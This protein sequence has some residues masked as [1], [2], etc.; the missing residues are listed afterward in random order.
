[1][2]TGA[3]VDSTV[4]V[5]VMKAGRGLTATRPSALRA[6]PVHKAFFQSAWQNATCSLLAMAMDA[7]LAV[8]VNA[9]AIRAGVAPDVMKRCVV[10]VSL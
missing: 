10:T 9:V 5:F 7:V 6:S 2:A 3:A 8:P 1:M 4:A